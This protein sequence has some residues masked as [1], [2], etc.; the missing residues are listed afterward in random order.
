[1]LKHLDSLY[2]DNT[3][4]TYTDLTFSD[5]KD[6]IRIL[7]ESLDCTSDGFTSTRI[8]KPELR[9]VVEEV[10]NNLV[11]LSGIED[12]DVFVETSLDIISQTSDIMGDEIDSMQFGKIRTLVNGSNEDSKPFGVRRFVRMNETEVSG[13]NDQELWTQEAVC[14]IML[15]TTSVNKAGVPINSGSTYDITITVENSFLSM[16]EYFSLLIKMDVKQTR[17]EV[18]KVRSARN[19]SNTHSTQ[20]KPI[21]TSSHDTVASSDNLYV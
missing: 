8:S 4:F 14:I 9:M 3:Q 10:K 15:F 6:G 16:V 12:K 7:A 21:G 18:V 13:P 17:P 2:R 20:A 11:K 19:K 1:M 5:I